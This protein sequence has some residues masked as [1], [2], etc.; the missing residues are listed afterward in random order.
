MK[1]LKVFIKP[2]EAPQRRMKKKSNLIF[3]SIQLSEI[4]GT[5]RVKIIVSGSTIF[6]LK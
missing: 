3:I 4:H 5:G 2:F 6:R 1:V